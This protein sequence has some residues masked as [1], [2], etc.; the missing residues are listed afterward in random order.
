MKQIFFKA[1]RFF[2]IGFAIL[3]ILRLIYGYVAY[4]NGQ[5]TS[6]FSTSNT[7][8]GFTYS[9]NNYASAKIKRKRTST[10]QS[11]QSPASVDQKYE[12]IASIGANT[13]KFEEDEQKV[14]Q[15]IKDY[16]ALIQFEQ[17]SGLEGS[18]YLHLA[19]GVDPNQFEAMIKTIKTIGKLRDIRIDK[20]DKTSEYKGL[21]TQKAAL[22]KTLR[23]LTQFKQ[24]GGKLE[25]L[26]KLEEKILQ[27][28]EKIQATGLNLG[29]FDEENEFCTIKYSLQEY[30]KRISDI[31][32]IERMK[33]AFDW[34]IRSYCYLFIGLF[35][36]TCCAFIGTFIV[37]MIAPL[38]EKYTT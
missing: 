15:T 23:N 27:I 17:S 4:P 22:E 14:R 18:Q 19:I 31:S 20:T 28:E 9:S 7:I 38:V 2:F 26:M 21:Q 32:I 16:N 29:E 1:V 34:T 5:E 33:T 3:F 36:A 35:F 25:E 30:K 12:K 6:T 37:R 11:I 24:Q 10:N 13:S 8:R